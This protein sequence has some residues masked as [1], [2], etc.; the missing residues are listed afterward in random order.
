MRW[1]RL[2]N[3]RVAGRRRQRACH[4]R[5]TG[6]RRRRR[7]RSPRRSFRFVAPWS[8]RERVASTPPDGSRKR[9]HRRSPSSGAR[10]ERSWGPGKAG[11]PH[12][13]FR[14]PARQHRLVSSPDR[15]IL[16]IAAALLPDRPS[17][18]QQRHE[19]VVGVVRVPGNHPEDV[20]SV[21]QPGRLAGPACRTGASAS[22]SAVAGGSRS[23]VSAVWTRADTPLL[24]PPLA[25]SVTSA[26]TFPPRSRT[27]SRKVNAPRAAVSRSRFLQI[28]G[29]GERERARRVRPRR[30]PS[31]GHQGG[32]VDF[33]ISFSFREQRRRAES[34]PLGRRALAPARRSETATTIPG[35]GGKRRCTTRRA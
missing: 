7:R 8:H 3:R 9:P 25:V 29:H 34:R 10:A 13:S 14:R 20:V 2:W 12:R 30:T 26:F 1:P 32:F 24:R 18:P 16:D 22:T 21:A 15:R 27:T 33:E 28:A 19:L 31:R 11:S 23:R 5:S 4:L 6:S 35:A 17:H